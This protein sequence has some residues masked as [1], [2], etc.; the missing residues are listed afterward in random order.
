M[1]DDRTPYLLEWNEKINSYELQNLGDICNTFLLPTVS[2]PWGCS[3]YLYR[4]GHFSL[5][6]GYQRYLQHTILP[7]FYNVDCTSR[8]TITKINCTSRTTITKIIS[9]R[10]NYLRKDRD[11][12]IILLNPD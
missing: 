11:D 8:T 9:A 7:S 2:C 1:I 3:D 12:D 5:D 10:D 6:I 4:S